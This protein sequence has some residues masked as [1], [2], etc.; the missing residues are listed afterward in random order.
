MPDYIVKIAIKAE[1]EN[2]VRKVGNA[3]TIIYKHLSMDDLTTIADEIKKNPG[4]IA[5]VRK[6]ANNPIV[7]AMY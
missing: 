5:K 7:K 4:V 6:I 3:L 1:N 2:E